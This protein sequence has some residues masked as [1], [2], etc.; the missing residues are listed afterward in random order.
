MFEAT[1]RVGVEAIIQ[2]LISSNLVVGM[3]AETESEGLDWNSITYLRVAAAKLQIPFHLK[4]GGCEAISDLVASQYLAVD[5]VIAPM[6]ETSFSADKFK[7]AIARAGLVDCKAKLL[8]ETV[9]G[10]GSLRTIL[11]NHSGWISGVNFGR[12]DLLASLSSSLGSNL[13]LESQEFLSLIQRG[14]VLAKERGMTVTVGGKMQTQNL[15]LLQ[16][17]PKE[18][19]PTFIETRRFILDFQKVM[20]SPE[21]LNDVLTVERDLIHTLLQL[22]LVKNQ[23]LALYLGELENRLKPEVASF[24]IL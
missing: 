5:Y 24:E 21:V 4:I 9:G 15:G 14:I 7:Q 3:K 20:T 16:K 12:T 10:V 22:G 8:I 6:V 2:T 17:W 13:S 11:D 1:P 23:H 19:L 18:S